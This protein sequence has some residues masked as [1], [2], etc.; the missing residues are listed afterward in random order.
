M[1]GYT[2]HIGHDNPVGWFLKKIGVDGVE[3]I[4]DATGFTRFIIEFDDGAFWD[5]DIEG[6]SDGG[7]FDNTQ[8]MDTPDGGTAVALRI[9]VGL[10]SAIT[11]GRKKARIVCYDTNHPNGL[12]WGKQ[13]KIEVYE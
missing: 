12:V 13:I 11:A 5:S 6:L 10:L 4:Q 1:A 3:S 9:R 8:T 2:A 7:V